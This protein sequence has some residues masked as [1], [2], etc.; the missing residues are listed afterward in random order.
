[1]EQPVEG[2]PVVRVA[3][4][5]PEDKAVRKS[6]FDLAEAMW[7]WRSGKILPQTASKDSVGLHYEGPARGR[8]DAMNEAAYSKATPIRYPL[9][10]TTL[11]GRC[12]PS[13]GTT[14]LNFAGMLIWLDTSSAA[15]VIDRLR[16]MQSTALLP[17]SIVPAFRTRWRNAIRVSTMK[18]RY[19][20]GLRN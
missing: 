18:R 4:E 3:F 8:R 13:P 19:P 7:L 10:R 1:M 14:N 15:P 12:N 6:R 11:Q 9:R 20:N 16:I 17:N 2:S 5:E